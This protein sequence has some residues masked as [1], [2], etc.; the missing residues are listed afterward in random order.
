MVETR[1]THGECKA[2]GMHIECFER[3]EKSLVKVV[4]NSFSHARR[5]HSLS[6]DE[7]KGLMWGNKYHLVR[8]H[9]RCRCGCGAGW[10]E[11]ASKH[12]RKEGRRDRGKWPRVAQCMYRDRLEVPGA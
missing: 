6:Q 5:Q 1:C 8:P 9:C 11:R 2:G 3:L 12:V 4:K 7:V 10:S